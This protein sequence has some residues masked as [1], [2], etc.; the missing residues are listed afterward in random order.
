MPGTGFYVFLSR[1]QSQAGKSRPEE[2]LQ[3]LGKLLRV[4]GSF[5]KRTGK[6]VGHGDLTPQSLPNH[7]YLSFLIMNK[8]E[9]A[10]QQSLLTDYLAISNTKPAA[11]I[12]FTVS[13]FT[14][15]FVM[16]YPFK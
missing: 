4:L 6:A 14:I 1:S 3:R 2:R 7:C 8:K 11:S 5:S 10:F 13:K 15:V 16:K 12:F 9:I